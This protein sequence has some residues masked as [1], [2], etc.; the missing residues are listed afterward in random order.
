MPEYQNVGLVLHV[1]KLILVAEG[2]LLDPAYKL[3]IQI[4]DFSFFFDL[5]QI[6][7]AAFYSVQN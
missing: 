2:L 4:E 1:L 5:V 7:D 3:K 6:A